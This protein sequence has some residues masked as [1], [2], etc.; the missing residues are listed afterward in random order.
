MKIS[1]K[2]IICLSATLLATSLN[3]VPVQAA[4]IPKLSS[5]SLKMTAKTST[6]L[7]LKKVSSSKSIK[8][9]IKWSTSDKNIVSIS[10]AS[11]KSTS[12]KITAKKKG[13]AVVSVRL[14]YDGK[15]YKTFKCNVNVISAPVL[16][17]SSLTM[18]T[19]ATSSSLKL[20]SLSTSKSITNTIRWY[21]SNSK[22]VKFSG[23]TSKKV[24][25]KLVAVKKG[26]AT[27]TAKVK[28]DGNRLTT[29]TCKVTVKDPVPV[30]PVLYPGIS[31]ADA[32]AALKKSNT[33]ALSN[34]AISETNLYRSLNALPSLKYSQKLSEVAQ[35]RAMEIAKVKK[36]NSTRVDGS[37]FKSLAQKGFGY[38]S[39][40]FDS[41]NL[42]TAVID[43][44]NVLKRYEIYGN[45][46]VAK[47]K[48]KRTNTHIGIGY[49][50]SGGVHYMVQIFGKE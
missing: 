48:I 35:Y 39:N 37:T 46:E 3:F 47:A 23:T 7:Q 20:K 16:S 32:R 27:I 24:T 15:K 49:Y 12:T 5:T 40:L 31:I 9:T 29:L 8:N 6:T 18:T 42:A 41:E 21:T 2:I 44:Y 33:K 1:K 36:M 43:S 30:N 22:V 19:K 45:I 14:K 4:T 10:G 11:S 17:K 50:I 38:N 28:A 26:T 25:P 34:R 13:R